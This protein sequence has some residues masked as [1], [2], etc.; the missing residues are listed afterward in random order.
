MR[1][2]KNEPSKK[3]FKGCLSQTLRG[4]F[5]NT[6]IQM[7]VRLINPK[8]FTHFHL[9]IEKNLEKSSLYLRQ[10]DNIL[11]LN[12]QVFFQQIDKSHPLV[13]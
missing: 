3:F 8:L 7:I 9:K 10:A 6:L 2:F 4:P 13:R 11:A 12:P 1:V 5:L